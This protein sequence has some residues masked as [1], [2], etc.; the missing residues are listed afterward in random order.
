[1]TFLPK[2]ANHSDWFHKLYLKE[3]SDERPLC[4]MFT[5][6]NKIWILKYFQISRDICTEFDH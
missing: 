3:S 6:F 5:K 1:M 2:I 4:K